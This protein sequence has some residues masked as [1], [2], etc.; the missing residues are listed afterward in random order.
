MSTTVTDR[1]EQ[2]ALLR[3]PLS[4]VWRAISDSTQFGEWFGVRFD[5]PFVAGQ[6]MTGR[7]QPTTVDPAVAEMQKPHAGKKFE[8]VVDRIEPEKTF[9][10]K[11]HPFAI[12]PK[13]DYSR[14]PM[15]L[16]M[17]L[18]DEAPGG[19]RL[20]ITEAGFD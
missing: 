10:F 16:V 12:D 6:A 5:G 9:S 3:A 18:L 19:V 20:T 1:I 7:I 2:Q 17:F 4:R 11:W 15:T 13:V 8:I 14:E